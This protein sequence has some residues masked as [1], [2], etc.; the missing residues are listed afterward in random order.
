MIKKILLCVCLMVMPAG[1][2]L[3]LANPPSAI[4][5]AYDTTAQQLHVKAFHPS[6]RVD[7]Y[8]LHRMLVSIDGVLQQEIFF[9]RQP[10]PWGME[11]DVALAAKPGQTISVE[12]FCTQ[13]GSKK[14]DLLI[15]AAKTPP[16]KELV[17]ST[18]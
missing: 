10:Y 15:K 9:T 12:L 18:N 5:L 2:S 14:E 1:V 7:R 17:A 13:G 16:K 8:Y 4:E 11:T 6:D 3:V